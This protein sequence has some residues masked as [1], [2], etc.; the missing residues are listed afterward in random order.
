MQAARETY[1]EAP[2]AFP[3]AVF[4]LFIAVCL[5]AYVNYFYQVYDRTNFGPYPDQV[6]A[7]LRKG[8][9]FTNFDLDPKRAIQYYQDA[10]KVALELGMDPFGS[11]VWGIK[12]KVAEVLEKSQRIGKAAE[13]WEMLRNDCTRWLADFG[14]AVL[15]MELRE[16][17]ENMNDEQKVEIRAW[18]K[19]VIYNREKRTL[20]LRH[21]AKCGLELGRLYASSQLW[22]RDAAEERMAWA[23]E[24][25]MGERLRRE[26]AGVQEGED[27]FMSDEEMG[28]MMERKSARW[29]AH[30][31]F[32]GRVGANETMSTGLAHQ[33]EESNQF[34]LAT[35]LFL[36]ALA[37]HGPTDCYTVI[38]SKHP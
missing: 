32:D 5:I 4:G 38:L 6:A 33:Y 20:I 25:M 13:V 11:E 31:E 9:Y 16:A 34:F 37:L 17:D 35:P 24:L 10:F 30:L 36:Q 23:L 3:I 29:R 2:I 12:T 19:Q 7:P 1:H 8:M 27:D 28:A 14:D 18:N 21:A 15:A 26:K 22:D